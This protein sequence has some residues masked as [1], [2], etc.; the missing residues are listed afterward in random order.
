[1]KIYVYDLP[2][3]YHEGMVAEQPGLQH[4]FWYVEH[5]I[6]KNILKSE[7]YTNDPEAAD[8]FFVPFYP[9]S[10]RAAHIYRRNLDIA[11]TGR[12]WKIYPDLALCN[13]F[14]KVMNIVGNSP[15]WK[16]SQ[17]RDHLFVFGQGE[18]ANTGYIWQA[19]RRY[20]RHG[21]ILG[22]ESVPY[23]DKDAFDLNKDLI[24]PGY[25]PWIEILDEVNAMDIP[26]NKLI[27]FRGRR[28]GSEARKQLFHY[29]RPAEDIL[30]SEDLKFALGGEN[31]SASRTDIYNYYKEIKG[32]VFSLCPAGWTPWS[33]RFYEAI[34]VGSIPVI[35]PGD[36]HPPFSDI[37]DYNEI[38]LTI[39]ID[40]LPGLVQR[41]R[42]MPEAKIVKMQKR[43]AEVRQHFRYNNDAE[44]ADAF[45][46]IL[47]TL[48][49]KLRKT[50]V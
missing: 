50:T 37:L 7:I 20:L 21:I 32:S 35:I 23:G 36:F 38:T 47:R 11:K 30:I 34:L 13:A 19:F 3:I 39:R 2:D 42:T 22:V 46:M 41:L 33:K 43:L 25:V 5:M 8:F 10:Y 6:H 28:W 49:P 17:G 15:Y 31:R 40:E 26:S 16:R 24:I 18:G 45:N 29:L 14:R 12:L 27:H 44:P 1:M 48:A 9:S 4:D